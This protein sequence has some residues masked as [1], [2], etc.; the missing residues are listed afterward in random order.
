MKRV[1]L[2]LMA[3]AF[4]PF[5]LLRAQAPIPNGDFEQWS[6]GA[7]VGWTVDDT[8]V[9]GMALSPIIQTLDA[10]GGSSAMEETVVGIVFGGQTLA[11]IPPLAVAGKVSGTDTGGFVYTDH[12]SSF[13]GF[14]K[15]S[16]VGSDSILIV[17]AFKKN[18]VGVGGGS[19][20]ISASASSYAAFSIPIN[21]SSSDAP[22]TA[23]ITIAIP[24][25]TGTSNVGTTA[26]FDDLAF[27]NTGSAVDPSTALAFS[28]DQNAPNPLLSSSPT[29]IQYSLPEACYTTLT[30]YDMAGRVV[31]IAARGFEPAG[32]HLVQFDC[33]TLP[34]GT[35]T[36]RLE[37]NGGSLSR[38]M[39]ILH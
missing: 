35:Y 24:A 37:A 13:T 10:H 32:R 19:E 16:P 17:T 6:N 3:F 18:G 34:A 1:F 33:S 28:L 2:L 22:D 29:D 38:V 11:Q 23:Y 7:P 27:S 25:Y 4:V 8:T 39:Q 12:P 36:Y 30:I 9:S 21:W 15:F 20:Y 5:S 31:A 26:E 14:Y